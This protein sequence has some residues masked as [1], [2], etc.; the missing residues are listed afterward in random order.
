M[1]SGVKIAQIGCGHWGKNL[2]RNFAELGTLAAIADDH[3]ETAA[4]I[5]AE[6]G[7]PA[8]SFA[9]IL[10]DPE[11]DG[12]A[13]ATPAAM[14]G[15]MALEAIAAGKHVFVE[16]PLALDP[17]EAEAVVAAAESAG[18]VLMI[19]HLLQ[20]HPQ[21]QA[22][23]ALV[24]ES[25][26]G[27][28]RYIY[29]NRLSLGKVRTEENVLW[30][31]APH[32]LSMVLA[33]TGEQPDEVTAQGAAILNPRIADWCTCQLGFASGV[34]AHVHASWLHPFKEQRLVVVGDR[35]MAVFEDSAP[36]WDRR[37]AIYPHKVDFG[38]PAPAVI[39]GE[40]DYIPVDKSEPLRTECGQFLH[41]IASGEA[42]PTDGREGLAVLKVLDRAEQALA[43]SLSENAR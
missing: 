11:I 42:A 23:L 28:L 13:L 3:P 25:R 1:T 18:R 15:R 35:G 17:A 37:L 20:Y 30:S 14:H 26:I 29:S 33:L 6:H 7:V 2:A 21:F 5:A 39:K 22:L 9:E 19:G 34:R 8:R 27:R 40:P 10:A 41:S 38:G 36:E 43:Q 4:R 12:V 24:R 31:F 16:K 32:D